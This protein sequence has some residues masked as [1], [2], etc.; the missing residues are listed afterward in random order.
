MSSLTK[1]EMEE[2]L[3]FDYQ[4]DFFVMHKEYAGKK[5]VIYSL[6][7]FMTSYDKQDNDK[8]FR[9]LFVVDV[10]LDDLSEFTDYKDVTKEQAMDWII[11]NFNETSRLNLM[12][13]LYEEHFP[14]TR[15][16]RPKF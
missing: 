15:Q 3:G 8:S 13:E 9:K 16:V 10:P 2:K 1:E 7:C 6:R 12:R 14:T 11:N 5:D 4:V